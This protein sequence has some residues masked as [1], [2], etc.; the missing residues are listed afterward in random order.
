[1]ERMKEDTEADSDSLNV[2]F[3]NYNIGDTTIST[4]NNWVKFDFI[5]RYKNI[6]FGWVRGFTY[7]FFTIYSANQ[8]MKLL[9]GFSLSDGSLK[10]SNNDS[11]NSKNK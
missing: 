11:R 6:W 2:G 8:F 3:S 1:M 5:L 7:V 4:G 9:R 10:S